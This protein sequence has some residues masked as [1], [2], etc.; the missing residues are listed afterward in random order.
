MK[1]SILSIAALVL[2][3]LGGVG[4]ILLTVAQSFEGAKDKQEMIDFTKTENRELKDQLIDIKKERDILKSDLE[5]RDERIQ[6]QTASI[7]KLNEQLVE[8]SNY[9]SDHLTGGKGYPF[10]VTS[11]IKT[12]NP[13]NDETTTFTL[14]NETKLPLYDVTAIVF[15]W[16]YL[17]SKMKVTGKDIPPLL[18][19]EDFAKSIIYRFDQNQIAEHSSII[20]KNKFD[21][22][23][24]LLYIKLKS[25]SSFVFEKMA[26][27][28][29]NG[30]I[31]QG[32]I[33]YDGEGNIL[34]EWMSPNIPDTAKSVIKKKY[35]LIPQT[36]TFNLTD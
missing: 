25:R 16:N 26:F 20:S 28:I 27:T 21:L 4:A 35:N 18:R 8:K 30:I 2:I 17:Q 9:I 19:Q 29:E 1:M 7:I 34:K 13:K 3:F 22:R 23:E 15:D 24:G 10:I 31:Y 36:V 33:V 14:T 32:F 6:T 5:K 11:S 12:T